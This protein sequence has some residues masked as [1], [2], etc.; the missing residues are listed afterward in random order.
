M[1]KDAMKIGMFILAA[2][3]KTAPDTLCLILCIE[4]LTLTE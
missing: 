2:V 1:K 4:D 3:P